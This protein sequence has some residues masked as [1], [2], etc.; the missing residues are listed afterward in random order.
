MKSSRV[1]MVWTLVAAA[2]RITAQA[3][4]TLDEALR[5]AR[6]ANA[7]LPVRSFELSIAKERA[8]EALAERWLKVALESDFIYAP[9]NGYDPA[10]TNLGEARLQAVARQPIYEGG[11]LKAGAARAQADVEAA[12][13]RY[14]IAEK[15]LDLEVRSRFAELA[16]SVAQIEVRRESRERLESYRMLL[17][18]RQASGQGVAADVRKTEVRIALAEAEIADSE[19]KAEEAR[20]ELNGLMGREPGAPLGIVPPAA[21]G[22]PPSESSS[23]WRSAPEVAAAEAETR[24]AAADAE[25]ARAERRPRVSLSGDLGFWASDTTHLGSDFWD[26]LW[27]DRG[28][29][30]GLVFSVPVWDAGAIR[31]RVAQADF[32]LKQAQAELEVDR[33]EAR[34]AYAQAASA[35][36]NLYR[37][38]E[39]LSRAVPDARDSY[40]EMESRYRGGTASALEVLDASDASVEASVRLIDVTARYRVARAVAERW[41]TP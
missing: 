35:A 25:I 18:G 8:S 20:L 22:A 27:R 1:L 5:E 40:L 10:L 23:D 34:L 11:A 28:Y 9:A 30:F 39:I 7:R 29:S 38:M 24:S 14:R 33:R 6:A 32:S 16:A 37:Q 26:R 21:P 4:L 17:R 19:Q 41:S 36:R 13:A 2:E 31:A 12:S 15:D 3:P